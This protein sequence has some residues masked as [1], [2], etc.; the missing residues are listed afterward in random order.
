MKSKV[1]AAYGTGCG[2]GSDKL[3][4]VSEGVP[5]VPEALGGTL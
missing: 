1:G 2:A 5:C 4:P 3:V